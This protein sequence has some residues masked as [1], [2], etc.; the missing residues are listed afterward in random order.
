MI[1]MRNKIK[2]CA[3]ALMPTILLAALT[4]PVLQTRAEEIEFSK[5]LDI[6]D[7]GASDD[8]EGVQIV[9]GRIVLTRDAAKKGAK[10]APDPAGDSVLELTDGSQLHG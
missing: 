3:A 9:N 8:A 10:P 2:I 7:N 6:S 5:G 1:K 4:I